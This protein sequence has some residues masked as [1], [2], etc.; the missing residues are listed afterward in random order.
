MALKNLVFLFLKANVDMEKIDLIMDADAELQLSLTELLS[1]LSTVLPKVSDL[2]THIEGLQQ[3]AV[4]R[5][6]KVKDNAMLM[7]E[8]ARVTTSSKAPPAA[9][10]APVGAMINKGAA[11]SQGRSK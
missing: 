11:K 2:D 3:R 1:D 7:A 10:R 9:V 6:Q 5:L 4:Q 8:V